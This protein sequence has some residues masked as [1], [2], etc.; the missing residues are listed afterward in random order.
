MQGGLEGRGRRAPR[1]GGGT[2]PPEPATC[3]LRERW[4]GESPLGISGRGTL[5]GIPETG[6]F[7]DTA[8]DRLT[9]GE[10]EGGRETTGCLQSRSLPRASVGGRADRSEARGW[11]WSGEAWPGRLVTCHGTGQGSRLVLAKRAPGGSGTVGWGEGTAAIGFHTGP[12]RPGPCARPSWVTPGAC[13]GH[14]RSRAI[15]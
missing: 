2:G 7:S 4:A 12:G 5:N 9:F 14:E 3:L 13:F 8:G 15:S 11:A 1:N 10:R 6:V